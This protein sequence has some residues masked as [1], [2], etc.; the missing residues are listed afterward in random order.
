MYFFCGGPIKSGTTFLQRMLNSH[1]EISCQP[2]HYLNG[3]SKELFNIQTSYNNKL[4]YFSEIMGIQPKLVSQETF[5]NLFFYLLEEIFKNNDHKPISG[6]NDNDF[7]INNSKLLLDQFTTSRIIY[8]VRNPF[9]VALST[10]DHQFRLYKKEGRPEILKLLEV[11][12][13]LDKNLFVINRFK[14]L[15]QL[16]DKIY[17]TCQSFKERSIFVRYEDLIENKHEKLKDLF[18]FLGA[19]S[20]DSVINKIVNSSSIEDMRISSRNPD[21]Y[22]KG[23]INSGISDLDRKTYNKA[24]EIIKREL[25]LFSYL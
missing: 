1:P 12:G 5:L 3:L 22:A 14:K 15:G 13:K 19:S 25:E 17:Q 9:D 8:I 2:E 24:S 7:I 23:R 10:W 16:M 21:F 6:I 20:I 18:N 4:Q 11:D